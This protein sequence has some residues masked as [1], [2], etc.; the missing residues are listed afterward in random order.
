M[1]DVRESWRIGQQDGLSTVTTS[2]TYGM[3]L[4]LIGTALD[5]FFVRFVIQREM[6]AGLNGLKE[7]LEHT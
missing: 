7:H 4:G 2:V 6:R 1:K 5:W 3:K